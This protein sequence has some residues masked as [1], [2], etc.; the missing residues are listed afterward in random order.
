MKL[1]VG[2]NPFQQR[3]GNQRFSIK[4]I[5]TKNLCN[6]YTVFKQHRFEPG[7]FGSLLQCLTTCATNTTTPSFLLQSQSAHFFSCVGLSDC[8]A[9]IHFSYHLK[10]QP[11]FKPILVQLQQFRTFWWTLYQLR[12]HAAT[13][14]PSYKL[15][16]KMIK[17]ASIK[18]GC[19]AQR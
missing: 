9:R 13:N 11:G 4:S 19:I 5:S 3:Y 15:K 17:Q 6:D 10:P 16:Q 8:T 1:V 12:Y 2:S 14:P 18:G 7:S